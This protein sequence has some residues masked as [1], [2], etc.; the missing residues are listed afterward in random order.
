MNKVNPFLCLVAVL[1][2]LAGCTGN[3]PFTQAQDNTSQTP[4][5]TVAAIKAFSYSNYENV[6]AKYV[7]NQGLVDYEALQANRGELDAFNTAFAAVTPETYASWSEPEQLA[8][9]INA[10]NAFTLQSI[11]DQNPLKKSIKDIPGVWKRR[12][13]NLAGQAE[14]LDNIEHDTI[15]VDFNE[16]RIHVALVCA[17]MSCPPLRNEPYQA[18]NLDQQLDEQV[19]QFIASPHGFQIKRNE[20]KVY[21]SSIF[22]WYG[23]DWQPDYAIEGKFAGS[24][25]ERAVLNFLSNYLNQNDREYLEK[26]NYKVSYL[27][28]DWS[29]NKQ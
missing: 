28:Y 21:L 4:A 24:A 22:K 26:G 6:L 17:A 10:Y 14:T 8:F 7:N 5:S 2:V 3:L 20:G 15:R 16:P 19:R 25:K 12:K 9:L 23:Q 27:N 11:I 1:S 13:F 18:E 29:L